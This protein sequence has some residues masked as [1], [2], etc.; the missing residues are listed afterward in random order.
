VGKI[1]YRNKYHCKNSHLKLRQKEKIYVWMHEETK[2]YH[3]RNGR[4]PAKR[5]EDMCMIS[6]GQ[7]N[8]VMH[9]KVSC[10]YRKE[11][12][13]WNEDGGWKERLS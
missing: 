10:S 11:C 6:D 13:S 4:C 9:E 5:T 8:V 2:C 3:D 1:N 7:G 12:Y